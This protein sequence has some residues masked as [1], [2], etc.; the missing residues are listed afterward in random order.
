[1]RFLYFNAQEDT[2]KEGESLIC[3]NNN[4]PTDI[5]NA[6]LIIHCSIESW[7]NVPENLVNALYNINDFIHKDDMN[8]KLKQVCLKNYLVHH[9]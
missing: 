1:M 9:S 7:I 6:I 8:L 5:H 2:D 3:I 4:A